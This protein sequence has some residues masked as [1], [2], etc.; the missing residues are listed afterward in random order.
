[1]TELII[2]FLVVF[3]ARGDVIISAIINAIKR[4]KHESFYECETIPYERFKYYERQ[5]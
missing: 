5:R 4:N 1:M 3:I 2:I